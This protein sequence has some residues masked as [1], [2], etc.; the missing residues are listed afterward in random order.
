[1]VSLAGTLTPGRSSW[2][3]GFFKESTMC[4]LSL[5]SVLSSK[6]SRQAPILPDEL[7]LERFENLEVLLELNKASLY[8][9]NRIFQ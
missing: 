9:H 5:P 1:M 6:S 2:R 3:S 7:L 8:A 4:I